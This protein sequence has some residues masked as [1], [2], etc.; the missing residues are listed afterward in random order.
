MLR[1]LRPGPH[2]AYRLLQVVRGR[3]HGGPGAGSHQAGRLGDLVVQPGSDLVRSLVSLKPWPGLVL[4]QVDGGGDLLLSRNVTVR[5]LTVIRAA[6]TADLNLVM[7][8]ISRTNGSANNRHS[9]GATEH[10]MFYVFF[11][12]CSGCLR[13]WNQGT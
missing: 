9:D 11:S 4:G 13:P 2:T 3:R 8:S 7:G 6:V 12:P 5:L 10:S 1:S